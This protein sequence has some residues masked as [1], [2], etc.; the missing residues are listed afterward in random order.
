MTQNTSVTPASP[1]T[2]TKPAKN[3]YEPYD[4]PMWFWR[5]LRAFARFIFAIILDVHISGLEHIPK[6]GPCIVASNHLAWMDVPLVPAYMRRKVVY[7][8]KEQLFYGKVGWL[9]RL[10]GAFPVKR[11]EAD[12]QS[13]R[14]ADTQL[15]AGKIFIIFPEGTRSKNH[16][17]AKG[18]VGLGMIALRS[19]VPVIPVAVW[20]SE[21]SLKTFRPRVTIT[22][23]EPMTLTP[24]GNKITREDI[25][26]AT[27]AVMSRIASMLPEQYR[28]VYAVYGPSDAQE[29]SEQSQ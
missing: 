13:L 23:G 24:K 3:L 15:K 19:G 4:T 7:M 11:G 14:A 17:L 1:K 28:G 8:A 6:Q 26:E 2:K 5:G 21:K 16:Q 25:E 18:H 29:E 12:R 10:L 9:V 20:G 22:Y 27:D